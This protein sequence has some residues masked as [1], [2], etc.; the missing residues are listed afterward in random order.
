MKFCS[1][2]VTGLFAGVALGCTALDAGAAGGGLQPM[3]LE[4][5]LT[6]GLPGDQVN[7]AVAVQQ[8]G[9]WIAWQDAAIDGQGLGI[10]ALRIAEDGTAVG[11]PRRV[12][13]AAEGDQENPSVALLP[14]GRSLFAWQG[15]PFGFQRIFARILASD[16][17]ATTGDLAIS[18]GDG[19]HQIDPVAIA[20]ADGSFAVGWSS[21]RQDGSAAYDIF[22][23]R[24]ANDGTL[25]GSEV[26]LNAT[27]GMNRRSPSLAALPGG[28]FL[29]AWVTERQVGVRNNTDSRGRP[30][31]GFGA[32]VFSVH[33]V[34]R[35]FNDQAEPLGAEASVSESGMAANPVASSLPDGSVFV[36]WTRRDPSDRSARLDVYG[37]LLGAL[38][39]AQG[40]E[41]RINV[42]TSGD[43][44]RPR[45]AVTSHGVL[46]VWS[47]MGQDGSWEGVFGR[48]IDSSGKPSG[49]EILINTQ[50]GGGQ[51]FPAVSAI[52]GFGMLVAYS[53]NQPRSGHELFAQRLAPLLLRAR[54]AGVGRLQLE[55]PTVAGGVYQLQ[56]STDAKTWKNIGS[57][58]TASGEIDE[59]A[60]TAPGQM[61]LY[62]IIRAR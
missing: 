60:I 28:G 57:T 18:G 55:W 10:S 21:Y 31:A 23:R 2:S 5:P 7:P 24:V 48:W 46:A 14:D 38:G 45:L 54:A 22:L 52:E 58:R 59:L 42:A 61:V 8:G 11:S 6:R 26:R 40:S 9:G 19:E 43:Q 33:V 25:I 20:L 4:F 17:T 41:E 3:G 16:G 39:T 30:I 15:G 13:E 12:N 1:H 56:S 34:S 53:S 27:Q 50:A 47:S 51:I 29:A 32:P 37:R 36:A 44:Y 62:R 49:D 35:V